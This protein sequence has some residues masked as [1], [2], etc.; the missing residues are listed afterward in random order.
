MEVPKADSPTLVHGAPVQCPCGKCSAA[1]SAPGVL[2]GACEGWLA[3]F[4]GHSETWVGYPLPGR[5]HLR[6]MG[7]DT[8]R[9][10]DRRERNTRQMP[11]TDTS[12]LRA[13]ALVQGAPEEVLKDGHPPRCWGPGNLHFYPV[14]RCC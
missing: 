7:G 2:R 8:E 14:S 5:P 9:Q 11:K 4:V 1:R 12:L 6:M 10:T 3:Q 13:A